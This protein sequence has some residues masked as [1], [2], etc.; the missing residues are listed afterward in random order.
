MKKKIV[1]LTT[2]PITNH[3]IKLA[4]PIIGS[5]LMQMA[6]NLTDMMW[7]GKVGSQAVA[8]VG[9]AGFF[10]WLGMSLLMITRIA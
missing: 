5:S 3:L 7:L 10:V 4:I 8:S 1:D 6:Y 2:G 9:S